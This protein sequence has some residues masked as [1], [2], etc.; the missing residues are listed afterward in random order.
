[1]NKP[2]SKFWYYKILRVAIRE[3]GMDEDS[4]RDVLKAFGA[5]DK[6]GKF[7]ASTMTVPQ[8]EKTL[9]HLKSLGFKPK[10]PNTV[11]YK[12]GQ[13]MKIQKLWQLLFEAKVM[14]VPYSHQA[15]SK[16][17]ARMT[18]VNQITWANPSELVKVIE[19]LK[20]MAWREGVDLEESSN[21]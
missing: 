17:S 21:T 12:D 3:I 20:A 19:A 11:S 5:K 9:S 4:Y 8:L 10:R 18:S 14:R 6:N 1:M 7:S 16:Y 15:A 2:K 13:L